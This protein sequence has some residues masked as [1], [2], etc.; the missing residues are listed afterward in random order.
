MLSFFKKKKSKSLELDKKS[1][2]NGNSHIIYK[3]DFIFYL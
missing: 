2:E 1:L 3:N